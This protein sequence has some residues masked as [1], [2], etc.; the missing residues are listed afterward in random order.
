VVLLAAAVAAI[1]IAGGFRATH[2]DKV[3]S[4]PPGK[5]GYRAGQHSAIGFHHAA[6]QAVPAAG[7][8]DAYVAAANGNEVLQVGISSETILKTYRADTPEGVAVTPGNSRAFIAETGQYDVIPVNVATGKEGNPIYVGPYPED[9]A[10]SPDGSTVYATVTSG[11]TGPG[12]SAVVAVISTSADN[13]TRDITVGA[14]PRQVVF[15]PD[16]KFAYVTTERGIDV[17]DT[18]TAKV[19]GDIPDRAGAQGIAVSPDGKTLYATSP[20]MDSLLVINAA[21]RRV[22]DRIPGGAEPYAVAV[23][24]DGKT[25]Y[26]TDMNSDSVMAI[27]AAT[28]ARVATISAGRLP[29]AVAVTPDGSQVWVGDILSGDIT[30]I[31]PATNA[32]AGTLSGSGTSNL[33]A[34]PLGIA[35]AKS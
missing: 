7:D 26:V 34:A 5:P 13:V 23:T 17:I 6:G 18:T 10:V 19:V 24:P 35:F 8:Y 16:G 21:S 2:S 33:D 25:V 14:G 4:A 15:S 20:S 29:G 9:L 28:R 12:G 22:T 1:G 3:A 32:V 31:N 27:D 30:V 11:D